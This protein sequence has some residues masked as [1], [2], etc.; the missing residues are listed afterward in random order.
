M[1]KTILRWECLCIAKVVFYEKSI[2]TAKT[3][4]ISFK[5]LKF[6]ESKKLKFENFVNISKPN[7]ISHSSHYIRRFI[8]DR[9]P[10][11][12]QISRFSTEYTQSIFSSNAPIFLLVKFFSTKVLL[13]L[14]LDHLLSKYGHTKT[15]IC[16]YM[17]S[18]AYSFSIE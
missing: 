15:R 16:V 6:V 18:Y 5:K 8:W 12:L 11:M 17:I 7:N 9:Q 2:I 14:R 4:K 3:V 1:E 13:F 10:F